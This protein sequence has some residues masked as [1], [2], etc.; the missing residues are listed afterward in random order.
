MAVR[1]PGHHRRDGG[2]GTRPDHNVGPGELRPHL[3]PLKD[4]HDTPPLPSPGTARTGDGPNPPM[5]IPLRSWGSP[6]AS[7]LA[8]S[9]VRGMG[10]RDTFAAAPLETYGMERDS[11]ISPS[12]GLR[13]FAA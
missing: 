12:G 13:C 9:S 3:A 2:Q 6:L 1:R 7:S 10:R 8:T 4:C 11:A 5:S